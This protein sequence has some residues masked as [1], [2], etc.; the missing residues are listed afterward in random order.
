MS[1]PCGGAKGTEK[2]HSAD[3]RS[4]LL[5]PAGH[6]CWRRLLTD[7]G[8]LLPAEI[9]FHGERPEGQQSGARARLSSSEGNPRRWAWGYGRVLLNTKISLLEM[10]LTT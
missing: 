10:K 4:F 7:E 6:R 2:A 1:P 5:H 3:T 8:P 9:P